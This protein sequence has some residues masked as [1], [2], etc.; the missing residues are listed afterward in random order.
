SLA[1][2]PGNDGVDLRVTA[3]GQREE[4]ERLL[5]EAA[6]L[7]RE[8]AGSV[9]YGEG[10]DDLAALMLRACDERHA[11]IAVAESCTGGMLGARLTAIPGSSRVFQGGVIAYSND[12]KIRELSV[13]ASDIDLHGAVSESVARAMATAV[14]QRFGAS[15]GLSI[16]GIAGPDGG[17]ED[18]PVGTVWVGLD[19]KGDVHAARAVLPGNR[20]EI[21]HRGTQ[22]AL[23]HLR[24]AFERTRR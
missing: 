11:T 23:D 3:R 14:R 18:K 16:T 8:R 7:L 17:T 5:S 2:L 6:A 10:D 1:F 15:I 12:V 20:E 13:A 9:V 21:R 22:L 19:M 24:R 4:T